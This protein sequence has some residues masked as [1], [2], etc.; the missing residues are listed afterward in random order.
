[1]RIAIVE[2]ERGV[3]VRLLRLVKEI[4][5]DELELIRHVETLEAA[6]AL[7]EETPLD[8]VFLDLNLSGED[9]F[10][11]LRKAVAES[12]QTVVVS[13]LRD[14][15][16]EAFEHGV[17]DFIPKPYSKKRLEK[18]LGRARNPQGRSGSAARSLAI[19]KQGR[20]EL[21]AVEDVAFVRGAGNY[22]EVLTGDGAVHL[23]GKTLEQLEQIL[24]ARFLRIH[25]ST[26]IDLERVTG[27]ETYPG[28]RYE[29]TL[30]ESTVLPVSRTRIGELRS[31]LQE[32]SSRSSPYGPWL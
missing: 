27:V 13:A 8:L 32:S 30:G 3:A 12:F 6:T 31:R 28:G 15:A 22:A 11:L 29:V 21:I 16:L 20:I 5:G 2:D 19:R 1:M 18:A 17:L 10:E 23:H 24:P 7:L 9:G 14:R 25:R 26:I 4:L